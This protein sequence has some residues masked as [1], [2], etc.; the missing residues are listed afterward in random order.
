MLRRMEGNGREE[1]EIRKWK[2]GGWRGMEERKWRNIEGETMRDG[3]GGRGRRGCTS[4]EGNG[5]KRRGIK[6][7]GEI[8]RERRD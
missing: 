4:R 2:G 8:L 1:E 5:G 7:R 3:N 6:R